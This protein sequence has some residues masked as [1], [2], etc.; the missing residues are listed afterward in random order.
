MSRRLQGHPN[1]A[2]SQV[3][4]SVLVNSLVRS[5]STMATTMTSRTNLGV[6]SQSSSASPAC[7]QSRMTSGTTTIHKNRHAT[8]SMRTLATN[9]DQTPSLEEEEEDDVLAPEEPPQQRNRNRNRNQNQNHQRVWYAEEMEDNDEDN[10]LHS[11]H[12]TL[13]SKKK[14]KVNH[15]EIWHDRVLDTDTNEDLTD[16]LR[17]IEAQES[18]GGRMRTRQLGV[19]H[20]DPAQDMKL[21]TQNYTLPAVA[22]ALRDREDVLQQAAVLAEAEDWKGLTALLSKH[23]PKY[24]AEQRRQRRQLTYEAGSFDGDAGSGAMETIRKALMRMPRTVTQSHTA[25]AAVVVALCTVDGIPS[26]LL[27]KRAAH[28]RAHPDEVCLPGGMVC[29]V[30]DR[31]IVATCLREM[32]EEI[33]GI[34]IESTQ[35]LGV[36]RCNWGEVHHLVGVAVT[37]VVCFLGELPS[38]L[39]PNPSEVSQIFTVPL[40]S[41]LDKSVWLHKEGL[42]PIF[43]GGPHP[44]WGLTGYILD[45]FGKDILAPH[46]S[47]RFKGSSGSGSGTG[48]N[49]GGDSSSTSGGAGSSMPPTL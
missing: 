22:S 38:D 43:L 9:I 30:A 12:T 33:E 32:Q 10:G 15:H 4:S 48:S 41:L 13:K 3:A 27:E 39:K 20:E 28:L 5:T 19:L 44:I 45:R 1:Q 34:D 29:S 42:A 40:E 14:K 18:G 35:V 47:S 23:H 49:T 25:R 37:P 8:G 36:F 7:R 21:L 2:Q 24:V 16:L 31:T 46:S 6:P 17:T 11:T 26:L